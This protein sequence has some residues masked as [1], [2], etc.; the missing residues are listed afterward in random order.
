MSGSFFANDAVRY[1]V[2]FSLEVFTFDYNSV[3]ITMIHFTYSSC[4]LHR[5]FFIKT[6]LRIYGDQRKL[7]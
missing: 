2:R 5:E 1:F 7:M 6:T 4:F 3:R